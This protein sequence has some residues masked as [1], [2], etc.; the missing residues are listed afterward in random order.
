MAYCLTALGSNLGDRAANLRQA[1]AALA[2]LPSSRLVARSNWLATPPIGGPPG[3]G[4]FLNAAALISTSLAPAALM[5]ELRRIELA[6]G[7]VRA[8]RWAARSLDVD[9]LLYEDAVIQTIELQVPHPR[10]AFRRFVL[11]PAAEV[12]AAMIHPESSW[13]IGELLRHLNRG[14]ELIAVAALEAEVADQLVQQVARELNLAIVT[15]EASCG[16][17]P[18]IARWTTEIASRAVRPKLLLATDTSA[19]VDADQ[20][21]RMLQLPLTGP[22][23]WIAP[24]TADGFHEALA[25]VQS[26]WPTLAT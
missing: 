7:R 19:G 9:L 23:A 6:L 2:S 18:G 20:L 22:V 5:A 17:R 11:E 3:Q 14:A 10:M 4:P 25:A 13:T 21:R 8:D 26:V 15:G 16:G 24:P 1:V 12:A